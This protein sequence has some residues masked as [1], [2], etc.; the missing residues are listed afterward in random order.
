MRDN[1]QKQST[2]NPLSDFVNFVIAEVEVRVK[3]KLAERSLANET[4]GQFAFQVHD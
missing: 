4:V 1:V 3:V 2:T